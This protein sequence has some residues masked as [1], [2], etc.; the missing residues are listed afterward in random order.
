[1]KAEQFALFD[2]PPDWA[3]TWKG[4]PEFRQQ[5]LMPDSSVIV[6]FA[7]EEDRIAFARLIGQTVT[8]FTKSVWYPPAPIGRI[9][10]KRYKTDDVVV[11]RY[12]IYVPTKG[13]YDT[14]LTIK[15]LEALRVPYFAVIQPQEYDNYRPVVKSGEILTLPAGLDGLVPARNWIKEHSIA[16]GHARHWQIDD[17]I[18]GFF[19]L[20]DNLKVR[21]L[22]GAFFRTMEE[23]SDRYTNVAIS[24]PNYKMFAPRKDVRPP[25]ILNTRIYSCSL[26]NNAIPHM[27]RDV[28]NDDTDICL[29]VLKDGL[30]T[31]LFNTMLIDKE[32]TMAVK[33]G[34]TDIY[35]GDGRLKMAESLQRQHPDVV[36]IT[37]KWGRP[38]HHV[39]YK[40]FRGNKLIPKPGIQPKEEIDNFGMML[41]VDQA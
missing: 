4:M 8:R 26:V 35:Q 27:W 30:C 29:R 17:N 23:F 15:S 16:A 7:T 37:M 18:R 32:T 28:Y 11:P 1:M 3:E 24:G 34:N 38:Q 19:R 31:A 6:N 40:V 33:G 14:A 2:V 22:T 36:K 12:P 25:L 21:V 39:N 9:V 20:N 13:R 5:N 41:E 10:D